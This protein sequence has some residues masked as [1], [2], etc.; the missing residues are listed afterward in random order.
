MDYD[1]SAR[2]KASI[3]S[4]ASKLSETELDLDQFL[5]SPI[6]SRKNYMTRQIPVDHATRTR[7]NPNIHNAEAITK[8]WERRFSKM[9]LIQ[10][11]AQQKRIIEPYL[12]FTATN[13]SGDPLHRMSVEEIVDLRNKNA[14]DF[15]QR[16]QQHLPQL[17]RIGMSLRSQPLSRN[18]NLGF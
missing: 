6:D 8:E 4:Q 9:K 2:S 7:S 3:I 16:E 15:K 17:R 10:S 11:K 1:L 14:G 18:S 12:L 13:K 5:H